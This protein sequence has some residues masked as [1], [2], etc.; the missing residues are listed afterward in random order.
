MESVNE[1]VTTDA[2]TY[3]PGK[4]GGTLPAAA[5]R[6]SNCSAGP[7]SNPYTAGNRKRANSLKTNNGDMF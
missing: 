1:I 7:V 4:A 2:R 3:Q 5:R 6:E